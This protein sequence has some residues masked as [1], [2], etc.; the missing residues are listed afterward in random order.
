MANQHRTWLLLLA[1]VLPAALLGGCQIL[2]VVASRLPPATVPQAYEGLGGH[3][4]AIWIWSDGAIDLDYPQLSLELSSALQKNLETARDKGSSRQ[5]RE[6]DGL[7]FTILPASVVKHQKRDP[8]LN[9]Q[10]ILQIAPKLEVERLIYIEFAR[11][12]TQGGSAAGLR[13]GVAYFNLS[14]VEVD[15]QTKTAR[16]GYQEQGINITYPDFGP[17]DGSTTLTDKEAYHGL[18]VGIADEVAL[19]FVSHPEP[20]PGP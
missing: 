17:A 16:F 2:G 4:A 6:L 12:T 20:E 3:T 10:P 14:V 13:R 19:R 7:K 15:L 11:F 18:V 1:M 9:L 8:S 5:K